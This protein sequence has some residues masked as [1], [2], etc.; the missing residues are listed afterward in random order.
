MRHR[1]VLV[2]VVQVVGGQQGRAQVVRDL[3]EL[4]VA[5]VL[6]ADAVVLQLDIQ[7]VAA[8]DVLQAGR[9]AGGLP[10]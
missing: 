3:Q 4:G 9:R 7:R 5:V 2:G 10:S 1:I 6:G 8:E